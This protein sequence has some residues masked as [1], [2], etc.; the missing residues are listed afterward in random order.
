MCCPTFLLL[1]SLF[2]LLIPL[3]GSMNTWGSQCGNKGVASLVAYDD[4]IRFSKNFTA[5]VFQAVN[6]LHKRPCD[7]LAWRFHSFKNSTC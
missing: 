1:F 7:G 3:I 6:Q 4:Y 2:A 5:Y